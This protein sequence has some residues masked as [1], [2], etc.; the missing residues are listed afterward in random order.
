MM[1]CERTKGRVISQPTHLRA[2]E[3]VCHTR[4]ASSLMLRLG[5]GAVREHREA[6]AKS[7]SIR[8]GPQQEGI[9]LPETHEFRT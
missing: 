5:S 7:M 9:E 2:L 4:R 6:S 8:I 3:L 1:Y